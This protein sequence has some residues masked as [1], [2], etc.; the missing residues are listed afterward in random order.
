[1]IFFAKKILLRKRY[2][3]EFEIG[4]LYNIYI[5]HLVIP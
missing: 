3:I 4:H 2:N 5:N 1:M